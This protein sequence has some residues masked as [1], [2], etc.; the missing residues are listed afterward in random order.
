MRLAPEAIAMFGIRV[1]FIL[2]PMASITLTPFFLSYA[3]PVGY[4]DE[5]RAY[6]EQ[7]AQVL[8]MYSERAINC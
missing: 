5:P 7:S 6:T 1:G 3:G 4:N 8:T 2:H